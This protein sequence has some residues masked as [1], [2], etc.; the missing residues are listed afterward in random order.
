MLWEVDDG[1]TWCQDTRTTSVSFYAV[2]R[3]SLL[4]A[5]RVKLYRFSVIKTRLCRHN[6]L[7]LLKHR[8]RQRR[9]AP[10]GFHGAAKVMRTS[11]QVQIST[12][13]RDTCCNAVLRRHS[14]QSR[15]GT[16]ECMGI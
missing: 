8:A 10:V 13:I 3:C 11:D 14:V 5:P 16:E 2:M 15:K 6:L 9:Y 7:D 1:A 4:C 12:G